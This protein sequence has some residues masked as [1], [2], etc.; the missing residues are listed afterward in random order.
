MMNAFITN[1]DAVTASGYDALKKDRLNVSLKSCTPVSQAY[2]ITGYDY[3]ANAF[4]TS[5]STVTVKDYTAVS[6]EYTLVFVASHP[7]LAGYTADSAQI[8]VHV[9]NN[10]N[11]GSVT[12]NDQPTPGQVIPYKTK[13]DMTTSWTS[14]LS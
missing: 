14:L 8:T 7:D 6:G 2:T 1:F 10:C 11:D 9:Q 12:L 13:T 5:G 4:A 3:C